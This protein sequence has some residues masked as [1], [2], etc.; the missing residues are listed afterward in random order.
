MRP[1]PPSRSSM[2]AVTLLATLVLAAVL[3]LGDIALG[4]LQPDL[5]RRQRLE[6]GQNVQRRD[7]SHRVA[8]FLKIVLALRRGDVLVSN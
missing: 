6:G 8:R 4:L 2:P 5:R 1:R 7:Q 3:M